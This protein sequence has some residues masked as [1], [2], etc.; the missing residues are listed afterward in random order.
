VAC[1]PEILLR[2]SEKPW[3]DIISAEFGI[4]HGKVG[5]KNC[6]KG[7]VFGITDF[8]D[9]MASNVSELSV[10]IGGPEF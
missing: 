9:Q 5:F 2:Y 8:S 10:A 4:K 6:L 1:F 3:G 7:I